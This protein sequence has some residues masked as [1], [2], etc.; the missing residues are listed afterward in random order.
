MLN[1]VVFLA[2]SAVWFVKKNM[3]DLTQEDSKAV[4]ERPEQSTK[5]LYWY[6]SFYATD[7]YWYYFVF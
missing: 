7:Q 6:R 4:I 1:S 3:F 2:L 5:S